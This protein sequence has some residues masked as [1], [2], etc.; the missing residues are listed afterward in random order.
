MIKHFYQIFNSFTEAERRVFLGALITF[1]V[2]GSTFALILFHQATVPVPIESNQY[3]EGVIGQPIAINPII[4]SS[5]DADRDL[6]NL[7]FVGL[8]D[9]ADHYKVSDDGQT[10][11]VTLKS[12]L[13]WS[14]GKPLTSDDLIFTIDAILDSDSR[15]PLFLTWQ[16]V[17]ADRISELEV[18]FTLRTPYA[19]FEDNLRDLKIIPRHIF[20]A[21]PIENF[22]LSNYNLEPVGSGPYVF[23]SFEKRRDGFIR[24]YFLATNKHFAGTKPFIKNFIIKFYQNNDEIIDAFNT[25]KIDG[26]GGLNPH[27]IDK[28][29][30]SHSIVEKIM[31]RY[32]AVFFN[33]NT[34]KSLQE[35]AVIDAL[36]FGTDKKRII[37]TVFSGKAFVVNQPILPN[38]TGYDIT[39][40]PGNEFSIEKAQQLLDDAKWKINPETNIREKIIG[41]Q[42]HTLSFS[43]I[44]PQI[45]FLTDTVAIIKEDWAKIGVQLNQIFLNPTDVTN[46][47][48]KTR[49]YEMLIFGNVLKNNP[50]IF[51]FWHSSERF[52][53]GLNLAL[54]DNKKV[55]A[56]LESIRKNPNAESRIKDL[57]TLQKTI[58]A[59]T[60]A[61]FLYSPT[62]L[63]VAPKNF[64]GFKERSMTTPADRFAGVEN[65]YRNTKRV[66]K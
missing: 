47:V 8:L 45:S 43:I 60:P 18:E 61:L 41:K 13:L 29:R 56:L 35:D 57:A 50:D 9:L 22:R 24:T 12:D 17:V 53:P 15:S 1:V 32:Y 6:I 10:W 38:I 11:S 37:E 30:L 28:L 42:L 62:Y 31:P 40:D 52:Y 63:Y 14:D 2:S 21:I 51:S 65:W 55:D 7:L 26:F 66:F 3:T 16:G 58:S 20:G 49:N 19:F 64:G 5:N 34:Q 27:D 39:A 59:D 54:Y 25:K 48:I 4:T 46:E 23:D 33:K 36:L 44:I